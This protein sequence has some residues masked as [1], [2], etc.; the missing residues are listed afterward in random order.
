MAGTIS[1]KVVD[2]RDE[3]WRERIAAQERSGLSVQQ[4]CR[5]QGLNNPS[6]YYWR[7]RL[8]QQTPVRF[9]LIE[10]GGAPQP[11]PSEH[12]LELV[13]PAGE[14]LRIGAGVNAAVL[15]TVLEALRK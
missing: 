1:E 11:A 12:C 10:T 6:F 5:E 4:F 13:L 9:A 3:Y 8:R 2:T 7:K 14:R 15:R